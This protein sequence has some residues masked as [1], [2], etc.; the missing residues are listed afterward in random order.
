M[1][2]YDYERETKPEF[3][4][5]GMSAREEADAEMARAWAYYINGGGGQPWLLCSESLTLEAYS[6][7]R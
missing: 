7:G 1:I 4:I 5:H 2:D 6:R 3:G